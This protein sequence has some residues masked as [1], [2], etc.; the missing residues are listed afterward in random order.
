MSWLGKELGDRTVTPGALALGHSK[1]FPPMSVS[2][3]PAL[4]CPAQLFQ[5]DGSLAPGLYLLIPGSSL[6][7]RDL[8]RF[9][10]QQHNLPN[11][12]ALCLP[13][14]LQGWDRSPLPCLALLDDLGSRQ[15]TKE[16]TKR[17]VQEKTHIPDGSNHLPLVGGEEDE[18]RALP[19]GT[20]SHMSL[21]L[22]WLIWK[23]EVMVQT[24]QILDGDPEKIEKERVT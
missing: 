20:F 10:A 14:Q 7:G 22:S 15:A 16:F 19:S 6:L 24:S 3:L 5:G 8:T 13:Y 18:A 4:S 2:L 1:L 17:R 9:D 23:V 21:S 11:P 12:L